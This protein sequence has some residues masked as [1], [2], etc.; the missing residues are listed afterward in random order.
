[1]RYTQMRNE[2]ADKVVADAASYTSGL[3]Y[4][5]ITV[6][7]L[8]PQAYTHQCRVN[9]E[10]YIHADNPLIRAQHALAIIA[11]PKAHHG[12]V[13][14]KGVQWRDIYKVSK[15]AERKIL[16][17]NLSSDEK[18]IYRLA[19]RYREANQKAGKIFSLAICQFSTSY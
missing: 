19:D 15:I 1:M 16:F 17:A 13:V 2:L 4:F 18:S 7:E 6:E 3:D 12:V 8:Q 11:D 9:V 14:E 10:D 5:K